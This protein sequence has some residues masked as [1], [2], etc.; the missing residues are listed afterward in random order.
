ML[1]LFFVMEMWCSTAQIWKEQQRYN[2]SFPGYVA[3]YCTFLEIPS[4]NDKNLPF[5]EIIFNL[6]MDYT[7]NYCILCRSFLCLETLGFRDV[8][9]KT[10]PHVQNGGNVNDN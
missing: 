3:Y 6:K 7:S 1:P 5:E 4:K 8:R 10:E 9:Q 2:R